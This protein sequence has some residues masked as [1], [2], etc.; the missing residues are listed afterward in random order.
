MSALTTIVGAFMLAFVVAS[1]F[2]GGPGIVLALPVALVVLGVAFLVDLR[3]RSREAGTSR[4]LQ[5][6]ARKHKVEFTERDEQ[7]LVSK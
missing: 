6:R 3:R 4:D 2:W 1:L 5:D 7:T